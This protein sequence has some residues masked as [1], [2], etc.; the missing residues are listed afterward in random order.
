LEETRGIFLSKDVNFHAEDFVKGRFDHCHIHCSGRS[1]GL[2]G[3][4][5][6]KCYHVFVANF[7]QGVGNEKALSDE[8]ELMIVSDFNFFNL[9]RI[10]FVSVG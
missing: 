2:L 3:S 8:I 10:E 1:L 6:V 4:L 5:I 9:F 7:D